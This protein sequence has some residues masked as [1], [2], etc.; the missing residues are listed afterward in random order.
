MNRTMPDA[1]QPVAGET[2]PSE[3]QTGEGS[4]RQPV[5][6]ESPSAVRASLLLIAFLGVSIVVVVRLVA[7]QV[8][9]NAASGAGVVTESDETARGR[10][11]DSNS[12]LLATDTFKWEIYV[13][14]QGLQNSADQARLMSGLAEILGY[15][16]EMLRSELA[17]APELLIAD[18]EAT[19]AQCEAIKRLGDPNLVWCIPRRTRVYP[20][21]ALGSS[22]IGFANV[23]QKGAAG[24]EWSYDAWLRDTSEWPDSRLPN[25][26]AEPLPE[27]W[28][29]YLPSPNGRDLVLYM[30]AAL[31]HMTEKRLAEAVDYYGAESGSII[32]MDPHTG[33]I[34]ALANVPSFDPNNY[35]EAPEELWGN[36]S[37][38]DSY[39][40]GSVFKLI[41]FAAALDSRKITPETLFE[42]SG[43]ITVSGR[44]IK[45]AED[46]AYGEVT[47]REALAKSINV[48]AAQICLD[49]GSETFYRYVRQFGFGKPTEVDLNYE[50][51]GIVKSPG[52]RYWSQYD[53]AA[54][55]FGQGI[56]VTALQML[57]ATA[58]IANNG[59][60][61]QPQAAKALVLNGKV[62]PVPPRM[63]RQAIRPETAQTL[64]R[65]MVY[66]VESSS[67]PSP[68]PG[69]RVA[70]K[71][72]TAEIPTET[73]YTSEETITS[74]AAF[75]P[76]AD[77][78]IVI[79]VKL[80]KP[81]R[82]NW[83]ERVVVPVFAEV[84]LDAIQIL[85]IEPDDRMP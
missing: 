28:K 82:S 79:L 12:V 65:M 24:A 53:Q 18:K 11:I 38:R 75:L 66:N 35:A 31:Q 22:V 17:D 69:F 60:L 8:P 70:G 10:I 48:V 20:M 3:A 84:A 1:D 58:A 51:E 44:T 50:S 34:L 32:I 25:S 14:P 78:Q 27:S 36:S 57:N 67:N 73:G 80:A 2:T 55:S 40:P 81:Q 23:D 43:T 30:N 64:A 29:L 56:S 4:A 6:G 54:N 68:V 19:E 21:G 15:S 33:G 71:T 42:D 72:G 47:A 77:P 45:N 41:T 26:Q 46:Q 37:V 83:A 63:M 39:E 59:A 49:M 9:G 76:A 61:L 74:F 7:Y 52:N 16:E 85:G 62:Y 13:R 5:G